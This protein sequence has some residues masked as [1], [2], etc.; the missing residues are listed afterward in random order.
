MLENVFIFKLSRVK[1]FLNLRLFIF[2]WFYIKEWLS[3]TIFLFFISLFKNLCFEITFIFKNE[4]IFNNFSYLWIFSCS[5]NS[6]CVK[7]FMLKMLT[8]CQ[9]IWEYSHIVEYSQIDKT[10][11]FRIF[12]HLRISTFW[13]LSCVRIHTR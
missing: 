11:Y 13:K 6:L 4:F 10:I 5:R 7:S 1:T 9:A 8:N 12:E 3:L 2:L